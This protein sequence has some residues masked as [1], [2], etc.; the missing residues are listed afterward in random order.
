MERAVDDIAGRASNRASDRDRRAEA[1]L[2]ALEHALSREPD[3]IAYASVEL[4]WVWTVHRSSMSQASRRAAKRSPDKRMMRDRIERESGALQYFGHL[5]GRRSEHRSEHRG[6]NMARNEDRTAPSSSS[7]G[8]NKSGQDDQVVHYI[9]QCESRVEHSVTPFH[10]GQKRCGYE[11]RV[12]HSVTPGG[13]VNGWTGSPSRKEVLDRTLLR[14]LMDAREQDNRR[15]SLLRLQRL[16]RAYPSH[17]AVLY[18]FAVVARRAGQV[19]SAGVAAGRLESLAP[20]RFLLLMLVI[21]GNWPSSFETHVWSG[22]IGPDE[23][24]AGVLESSSRSRG[25]SS[26]D[27]TTW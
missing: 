16:L 12:E 25:G 24:A 1:A 14:R 10:H 11:P 18:H 13:V 20:Q 6:G 3:L 26:E 19:E 4:L 2:V 9:E 8:D 22:E 23:S 5:S 7:S 21:A 15:Q 17:P 27:Q